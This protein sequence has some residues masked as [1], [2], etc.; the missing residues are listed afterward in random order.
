[1]LD[2]RNGTEFLGNALSA[3]GSDVCWFG[4]ASAGQG[5]TLGYVRASATGST[6]L[7]ALPP[8]SDASLQR[9]FLGTDGNRIYFAQGNT[10]TWTK[11]VLDLRSAAM[12]GQDSR[13][14]EA[15][16]TPTAMTFDDGYMY[17]VASDAILVLPK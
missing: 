4:T 14:V 8:L 5:P 2:R 11:P 12:S 6:E 17:F 7:V 1:M 3:C 15:G 9:L 10:D 16:V 13:V